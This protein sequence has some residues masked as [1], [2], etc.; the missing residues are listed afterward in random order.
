MTV[1]LSIGSHLLLF[2]TLF[3]TLNPTDV[4]TCR[5]YVTFGMLAFHQVILQFCSVIISHNNDK[6]T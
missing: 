5:C 3:N 6:Q 2:Y 4:H 1:S